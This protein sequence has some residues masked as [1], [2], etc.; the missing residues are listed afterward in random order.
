MGTTKHEV[1]YI[2]V[3]ICN[4][5]SETPVVEKVAADEVEKEAQKEKE[6]VEEADAPAAENGSA[7]SATAKENGDAEEVDAESTTETPKEAS[8]EAEA[9]A[10]AEENGKDDEA[11]SEATGMRNYYTNLNINNS[12]ML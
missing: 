2:D 1:F 3:A 9:A 11:E 8:A 10:P 7:D 6:V 12:Y 4:V 5:F